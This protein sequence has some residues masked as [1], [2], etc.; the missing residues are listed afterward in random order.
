M[1]KAMFV[2]AFMM[3]FLMLGCVTEKD[4]SAPANELVLSANAEDMDLDTYTDFKTYVFRPIII[5]ANENIVMQK[6]VSAAEAGT[7][8]NII[9]VKQLSDSDVSTLETS[10]FQFDSDR[11]D[12]ENACRDAFGMSRVVGNSCESPSAC[13]SLCGTT[14]CQ[15]YSYVS[16]LLG[17]WLYDFSQNSR[18]MDADVS[19]VKNALVTIQGADQGEKERIMRKLNAIMDRT[20][21]IDANPLLNDN[22]FGIC[23]PVAYD[24]SRIRTMLD[25]MGSYDR[26][27]ARYLYIVNIKFV[28]SGK[29]YSEIKISDT[30]PQPMVA[31][32]QNMTIVQ[33]GGAYDSAIDQIT[34][35]TLAFN[36]Y[37]QYM[38]SYSFYSG[39]GIR[40]DIFENWPTP[41]VSTKV[42]S[43]MNSPIILFIIS[44]SQYVYALTRGIGYY[45][46]LACVLAF[47]DILFFMI[48]L[49]LRTVISFVSATFARTGLRDGLVKGFGGANPYWKEYMIACVVFLVVGYGL[50]LAT[51]PIADATLDLNRLGENLLKN[52]VGALSLAFFFLGLH[53]AYALLEDKFKGVIAG[54]KYYENILDVSPKANELRFAKLKERMAVLKDLV[55][56]SKN[57]DV[58][59]E[60]ATLISIPI[61]RIEA[62]LKRS[63]SERAVKEL[64]DVYANR[65][66]AAILRIG[67]KSNITRDYWPEWNRDLADKL[68]TQ[69]SVAFASMSG[70]PSE[71]R[72]WAANKFVAENEGEGYFVDSEGIKRVA[73]GTGAGKAGEIL[74]KL[75]SKELALGGVILD[76]DSIAGIYSK[77]GNQTLEGILSWKISN[78]A[79]TLGQKALGADYVGIVIV[80]SKNAAIFTKEEEK[81]GVLFAQKDKV[82]DAFSEF[83]AK[84]KRL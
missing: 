76:R 57:I 67:E 14:K 26:Q 3:L 42:V 54:R 71:W 41:K 15:Q 65:V 78:Y 37:P 81:E 49:G 19:D 16:D 58:S 8:L 24:N 4:V 40:E 9:S 29:D 74:K 70:I 11:K 1:R 45:P 44:T 25:L 50:L 61:D 43:L 59:E 62:L 46:A 80:G 84:L 7:V 36:L 82:Q 47:W 10:I 13:A 38:L 30:V 12:S 18:A 53:I 77:T 2:L 73:E 68:A 35:P 5:D 75:V 69:D 52:P 22:M 64:M 39:Q 48:V 66:E 6:S 34:W 21:V 51:S 31:T 23:K 79:K 55:A 17:Y 72:A 56:A 63:G 27:P 28:I 20:L 60:K 83:K 33:N 32:L